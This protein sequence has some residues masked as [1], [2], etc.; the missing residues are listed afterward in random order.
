MNAPRD[1]KA[2]KPDRAVVDANATTMDTDPALDAEQLDANASAND[3][4]L[5]ILRQLGAE[6]P[7][8]DAPEPLDEPTYTS[9][10]SADVGTMRRRSGAARWRG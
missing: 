7:S 5:K 2:R 3:R 4:V 1:P 10:Q 8:L 6:T 9:A